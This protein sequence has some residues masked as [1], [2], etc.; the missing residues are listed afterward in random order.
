MEGTFRANVQLILRHLEHTHAFHD[1][2][3]RIEKI[4]VVREAA[5]W[6]GLHRDVFWRA[7]M[8]LGL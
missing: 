4:Y 2:M 1:N 3:S 5:D 6:L 7:M 8:C